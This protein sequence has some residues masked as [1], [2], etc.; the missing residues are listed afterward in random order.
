MDRGLK[1]DLGLLPGTGAIVAAVATG[2]GATPLVIGKPEP[3]IV[4]LALKRLGVSA[5]EAIVVGDNVETDMPAG[6]GAGVRTVLILTGV[7][8]REDAARAP[9]PPT[10]IAETFAEVEAIVRQEIEPAKAGGDR[11]SPHLAAH[12]LALPHDRRRST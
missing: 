8:R 5:D 7:C 1:T 3:L 6:A 4:T 9:S 11:A 2:S 12:P 10:W